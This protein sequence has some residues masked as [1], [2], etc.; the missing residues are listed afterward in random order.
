MFSWTHFTNSKMEMDVQEIKK[1][2]DEKIPRRKYLNRKVCGRFR[3]KRKYQLLQ[4]LIATNCNYAEEK[5]Q[6]VK[7]LKRTSMSIRLTKGKFEGFFFVFHFHNVLMFFYFQ[8]SLSR[9]HKK[10]KPKLQAN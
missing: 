8:T 3:N 5:N 6:I 9:R 10:P 7:R 1:E 2:P 4:R